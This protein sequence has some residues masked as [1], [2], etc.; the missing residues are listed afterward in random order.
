M[1][2]QSNKRLMSSISP[3]R[4]TS[5]KPAKYILIEAAGY[6][7]RMAAE[8]KMGP[9]QITTDD[10]QLFSKYAL[11]QWQGLVVKKGEYL[12]DSM[13]FPDFAFRIIR[14][15]P[16]PA[17][18]TEKTRFD[19]KSYKN[20]ENKKI[21]FNKLTTS[22]DDIIGQEQAKQKSK[23]IL[24]FIQNPV[25]LSSEWA[26]RNILFHGP[27]GTGKTMM[28]KA[29]SHK[30]QIPMIPIKANELIGIFVGEGS[31]KVQNL[32]AEARKI[33]PCII[34]IDELDAVAL[35]RNYQQ[36]RGDVIE[37]VSALLG[38]MDG[39]SE[40]NGVITIAATNL[41]SE[42][43]PAILNRFE[44]MIEFKLPI[45]EERIQILKTKAKSSP[46]PFENVNW[47]TI[48]QKTNGW[49]GR[50]L[51][52][53]LLKVAIHQAVLKDRDTIST[54][55]LEKI[56]GKVQKEEKISHYA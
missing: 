30:A 44:E 53:Q 13:I 2:R 37:I 26:P 17:K 22:F 14:I 24:K 52:D 10:P 48:S 21:T 16:N 45:L 15:A 39:I 46:I 1:T 38:E 29:L 49:S 19:L 27:P 18:I 5:A 7:L 54:S 35:K 43:D 9:H 51:V 25:L 6:P 55:M 31:K 11:A 3:L 32:F 8:D 56:I 47:P 23:I 42:I 40:N 36:I 41:S 28:A 50:I 12:F 4:T 33:S 34:F 20:I